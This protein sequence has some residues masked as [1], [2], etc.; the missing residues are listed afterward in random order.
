M[1][2]I[3]N[4]KVRKSNWDPANSKGSFNSTVKEVAGLFGVGRKRPCGSA[5][6]GSE[7]QGGYEGVGT[8][9]MGAYGEQRSTRNGR[10]WFCYQLRD[11]FCIFIRIRQRWIATSIINSDCNRCSSCRASDFQKKPDQ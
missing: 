6:S 1:R 3:E 5:I 10:I 4:R 8:E 11:F 7:E 2:H 9:E